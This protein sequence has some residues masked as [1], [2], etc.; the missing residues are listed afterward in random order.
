MPIF[1]YKCRKCGADFEKLVKNSQEKTACAKCASKEVE[2]KLSVFAASVANT[3]ACPAQK[4][5]PA[6]DSHKC[7]SGC[8]HLK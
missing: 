4:S 7:S 2:R 5:C 8:C 6:A 1:E 3:S